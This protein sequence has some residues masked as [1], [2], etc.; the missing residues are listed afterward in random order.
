MNKARLLKTIALAGVLG[1]AV[2]QVFVAVD[3]NS[4]RSGVHEEIANAMADGSTLYLKV[5]I[6]NPGGTLIP[7][8]D[9]DVVAYHPE[10]IVSEA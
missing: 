9:V 10:T 2:I 6:Y 7:E 4:T 1:A 3:T 8:G 5:E